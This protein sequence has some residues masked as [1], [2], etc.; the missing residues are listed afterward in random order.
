MQRARGEYLKKNLADDDV[1]DAI[2]GLWTAHRIADR[3]A[4]TLPASP[5][6]DETPGAC[7]GGPVRLPVCSLRELALSRGEPV[8]EKG[9]TSR[10]TPHRDTEILNRGFDPRLSVGSAR[11]AVF[12]SST[13]VFSSPES[14]ERAFEIALGKAQPDS[15]EDVELIYSRLSHPNA[16]ILE[17]RIVPLETGRRPPARRRRPRKKSRPTPRR[18]P[19]PSRAWPGPPPSTSNH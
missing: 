19:P 13:Y 17:A 6:R 11:P 7:E 10:A 1:A 4:E 5:P 8:A 12:R 18:P 9:K 3:T 15:G 14:A 2:A 16:E